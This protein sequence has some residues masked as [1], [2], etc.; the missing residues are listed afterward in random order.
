MKTQWI[1]PDETLAL[2]SVGFLIKF[3]N[4]MNGGYERWELRDTPACTNQSRRPL[5]DGWCGSYNDL[6]TEAYGMGKVIRVAKNS[7]CLVESLDGAELQ[8]A[9]DSLGYP[10]LTD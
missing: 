3:S 4:H 1:G 9:L 5:L 7:R 2:G 6:S 8:T 10:D